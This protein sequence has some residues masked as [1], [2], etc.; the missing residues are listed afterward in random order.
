MSTQWIY[1]GKPI[2][3]EKVN[4]YVAFVYVIDN[5]EDNLDYI[6]KKLI[7]AKS[8]KWQN[9]WSSSK[10][11]KDD[12]KRLGKNKFKRTILHLCK[13]KQD[14][15]YLELKEQIKRKVM[16]RDNSYNSYIGAIIYK[17]NLKFK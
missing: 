7:K 3:D 2:S 17:K 8:G 9:Y 4:Q 15:S 11:L 13:S 16:E 14:A 10:W 6:G 12:V 1:K 5:L